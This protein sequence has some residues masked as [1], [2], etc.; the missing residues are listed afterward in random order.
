MI[1]AL[2]ELEKILGERERLISQGKILDAASQRDPNWNHTD[3]AEFETINLKLSELEQRLAFQADLLRRKH[4][5]NFELW[6]KER[7][8]WRRTQAQSTTD[9]LGK[10]FLIATTR[11]WNRFVKK[12][13][14]R[15]YR[16]RGW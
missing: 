14:P 4:Q 16:Q 13:Y 7:N 2:K 11:R 5:E 3:Q 9:A 1:K 12:D 6:V 10:A 8:Q 15:F